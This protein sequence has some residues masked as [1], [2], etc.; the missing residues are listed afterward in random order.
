MTRKDYELIAAVLAKFEAEGGV[1]VERDAMAYDLADA[2][3]ADNPRFSREVFLV[4]AGVYE[5]CHKCRNRA[6]LFTSQVNAC[7]DKHLPAWA[8]KVRAAA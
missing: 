8:R 3:G 6:K 1:T 7:S 5:K 4:A 2:L